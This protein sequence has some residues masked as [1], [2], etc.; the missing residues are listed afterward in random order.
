MYNKKVLSEATKNLNS[1]KAPA[2]KKNIIVLEK[3]K[4]K[5]GI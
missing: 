1:T 4:E 2:K 5:Y 3:E